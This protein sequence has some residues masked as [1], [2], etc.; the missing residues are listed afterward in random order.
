MV[1][2]MRRYVIATAGCDLIMRHC[3]DDAGRCRLPTLSALARDLSLCQQWV[4]TSIARTP[5]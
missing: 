3:A 5:S 4:Y 1:E 2:D